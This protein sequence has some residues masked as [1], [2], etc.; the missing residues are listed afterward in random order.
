MVIQKKKRSERNEVHVSANSLTKH[1][2]YDRMAHHRKVMIRM[3]QMIYYISY[4][5]FGYLCGSILFGYWIPKLVRGIDVR[6]LSDDG[7][8]GAANTFCHAGVPCGIAV[9]FFDLL[10][11][12]LPVYLAAGRLD[13]QDYL[14]ALVLAAPVLGHILPLYS[15]FKGGGKGIATSFG[16]CLG[17]VPYWKVAGLLAFW[18]IF[19][20]LIIV[21]KPHALRTAVAYCCWFLSSFLFFRNRAFVWAVA[22][23]TFLVVRKHRRE[24]KELRAEAEIR[25]LFQ[26][27]EYEAAE[28][29]GEEI[30]EQRTLKSRAFKKW[31]K[32]IDKRND[33]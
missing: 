30:A 13:V 29:D 31:K 32:R 18:Y 22:G 3:G 14:F 17:L 33:M 12:F 16:V 20:S 4:A 26:K 21:V 2:F 7:N 1:C 19:Y 8:P 15:S 6:E 11:G 24:L 25:F 5:I 9:L 28:E 23:I 27:P 10:K